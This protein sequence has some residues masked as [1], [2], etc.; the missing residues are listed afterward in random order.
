MQ[1]CDFAL[2]GYIESMESDHLH[3]IYE[4]MNQPCV[5]VGVRGP[6]PVPVHHW[7]LSGLQ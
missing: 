4:G 6:V 3:K 2:E 5:R 1:P 7:M